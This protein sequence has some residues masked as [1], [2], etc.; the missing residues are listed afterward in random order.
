[1]TDLHHRWKHRWISPKAEITN[2]AIEGLGVIARERIKKDEAVGVLG[3]IIVPASEIKEYHEKVGD[4]GIQIDDEFFICPAA[5]DEIK[6]TG[7]FNHSCEPNLGF[8]GSITFIAMRDI[9]EGEELTFDYAMSESILL[10]LSPMNCNCNKVSCRK[11]ITCDDWKL[12]ALQEK[13]TNHFSPYLEKKIQ[14]VKK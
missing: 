5:Y 9:A 1:M 3:G 4:V 7:V 11:I 2:S 10:S 13:Y 12:K 14:M 8:G 6:E